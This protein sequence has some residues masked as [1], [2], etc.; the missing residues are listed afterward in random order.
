MEQ[1]TDYGRLAFLKTGD[2]ANRIARLEGRKEKEDE[3]NRTLQGAVDFFNLPLAY[4]TEQPLFTLNV[5][6]AANVSFFFKL[7]VNNTGAAGN[8]YIHFYAGASLIAGGLTGVGQGR[9]EAVFFG[10]CELEK[11]T[12]EVRAR[13][14][15]LTGRTL[16][17]ADYAVFGAGLKFPQ[18]D[19]FLSVCV[20]EKNILYAVACTPDGACRMT[21]NSGASWRAVPLDASLGKAAVTLIENGGVKSGYRLIAVQNGALLVLDETFQSTVIEPSGVECACGYQTKGVDGVFTLVYIK[22]GRAFCAE[23]PSPGITPAPVMPGYKFTGCCAVISAPA[24]MFILT[25]TNGNCMLVEAGKK[26]SLNIGKM[27]KPLAIHKD[28][29]ITVYYHNGS[30]ISQK[31]VNLADSSATGGASTDMYYDWAAETPKRT[32]VLKGDSVSVY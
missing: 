13:I 31:R 11:G 24:P 21:D 20:D 15:G 30:G 7:R 28:G 27:P 16:L 6:G 25:G 1:Y 29:V 4:L 3:K 12:Y 18:P 23:V 19:N 10:A 22:G 32:V 17:S 14:E 5:Y 8:A 26:G 2:L 9:Q